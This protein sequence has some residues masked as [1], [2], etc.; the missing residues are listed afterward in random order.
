MKLDRRNHPEFKNIEHINIPIPERIELNN[1]IETFIINAGTQDVVKI[2]ITFNAG[3]WYQEKPIIATV[4]NEMLIEGTKEY[5]SQQI[6]EKLDFYGAFIHAQPTK[7]FGNVTLYTLKKYLPETILIL[8]DIIKNPVFPEHELNT[9]LNKRKQQF[10]VELEKVSNVARREFNEQLFGK[11]HPY[12]VKTKI[13][14]YNCV[15]QKDI[16]Q[17]HKT[18]YQSNKCKILLSGKIDKTVLALLEKHFGNE[19]WGFNA[20]VESA[21]FDIPHPVKMETYIEKKDV[22]QSA[23]RLGKIL[24]KNGHPDF[25]KLNIVNTILGGYFGSRLMKTIREEKGYTYGINSVLVSLKNAG[26]L[27]ILS[28]V[29]A[30]VAKKAIQEILNEVKKLREEKVSVEELD[31]VRNYM[32]GDLLRSFDGPFEIS[33]S[34]KNIIDFGLE[35]NYFNEAID[36]IK[37]ITPE[38]IIELANKYLHEDTLIRTIAGKYN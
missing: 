28:E 25:H 2:D 20:T 35:I 37:N 21:Q 10:Q 4:V 17:F 30:D 31:L 29:G 18:H 15:S 6:A 16:V 11:S 23:I 36:A 3:G 8:E 5:T 38:E 14:D 1:G 9:Y 32:L 12:G 7:D 13:E 27:V 24:I 33:S 22:S 34:F 26:F 19:D